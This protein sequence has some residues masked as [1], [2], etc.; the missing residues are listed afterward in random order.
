MLRGTAPAVP[1]VTCLWTCSEDAPPAPRSRCV[2]R[3]PPAG[4]RSRTR[5]RVLALSGGRQHPVAAVLAVLVWP[6]LGPL[7]QGAHS[8]GKNES[9]LPPR[10][11]PGTRLLLQRRGLVWPRLWPRS[12]TSTQHGSARPD[13]SQRPLSTV[14]ILAALTIER[15][16]DQ[17]RQR[18]CTVAGRPWPHGE[19]GG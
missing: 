4:P 3:P 11:F 18:A 17:L 13:T 9:V 8:R 7:C 2:S 12:N 15:C 10:K 14:C 1:Y 19:E 16:S 6:C 5:T